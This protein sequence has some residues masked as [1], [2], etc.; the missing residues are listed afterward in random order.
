MQHYRKALEI[1]E[2][3]GADRLISAACNNMAVV[4]ENQEQYDQA[5]T[6]YN[7]SLEI[8]LA[9]S[10]IEDLGISWHNVGTV[11]RKMKRYPEARQ[12][13]L[14]G[15]A[16]IAEAKIHYITTVSYL[17][18]STLESEIANYKQ[19]F[20]YLK[21]STAYSDSAEAE[22]RMQE[23]NEL[24]FKLD[25]ENKE[26]VLKAEQE[27]RDAITAQTI[28]VNQF[29][30]YAL[31]VGLLLTLV[32]TLVT[33]QGYRRKRKDNQLIEARNREVVAKNR[34]ITESITYA[35]RI[36]TAI[37]PPP[38][39]IIENFSEAFIIYILKDIVAGDFYW[40]EN[41]NGLKIVAA[42]DCT[43]HGVPGALVSIVCHNAL[44]RS[45]NE[46]NLTDPG[47]ILDK[48]R[49]LD[50]A[51]FEKSAEDVK[52]GMD[53]SLCAISGSEVKWSGANNA[54]WIV[55]HGGSLTE[56]KG[57]KQPIGKADK[58]VSFQTHI[59][60]C[61]TGD[62]LYLLTDGYCDQFGGPK[63]KKLKSGGLK[64]LLS[65][66]HHLPMVE[67][68]KSIESY[69]HRWKGDLE[70]VDDVCVIGIRL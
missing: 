64:E 58:P 37:L 34:E 54:L 25:F 13:L 67:Q 19:A 16:T 52:D 55:I 9:G 50:V 46:F 5:L 18:L 68:K 43:G 40:F 38:S 63:G 6:Y 11:K 39:S 8:D 62:S 61:A 32:L 27:K 14:T 56:I 48:T 60:E 47:A 65:E 69:F 7:R 17:E 51:E 42:A 45:V 23:F 26:A 22:S 4:Y 2:K 1:A 49:T 3:L 12:A 21:L 29:R 10:E 41:V 20:D 28:R 59:S 36:Q 66:I 30:S 57:N 31:G 44:N 70:Q 33:W 15:I 35:K 53:I 24:Q